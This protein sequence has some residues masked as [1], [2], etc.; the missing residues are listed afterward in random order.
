MFAIELFTDFANLVW[1][2]ATL[3]CY[4]CSV[5]RC[6]K[7]NI[8]IGLKGGGRRQTKNREKK[9]DQTISQGRIV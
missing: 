1:S 3:F 9:K 5:L 6:I 7:V 2:Y 8:G 4:F